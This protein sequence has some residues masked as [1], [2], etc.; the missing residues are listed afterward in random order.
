MNNTSFFNYIQP[1]IVK[2]NDNAA[3]PEQLRNHYLINMNVVGV[4]YFFEMFLLVKNGSNYE[5]MLT[6]KNEKIRLTDNIEQIDIPRI[7]LAITDKLTVDDTYFREWLSLS[8]MDNA[9]YYNGT[10]NF[11][12]GVD[13][14]L[15]KTA[16]DALL[17]Q[18]EKVCEPDTSKLLHDYLDGYYEV[19]QYWDALPDKLRFYSNFRY[20]Q[21]KNESIE[22]NQY[23]EDELDNLY[24]TFC[25]IILDQTTITD[26]QLSETT[27][28]IYR[29]VLEYYKGFMSDCASAGI[30]VIL[31][32][33]FSSLPEYAKTNSCGCGGKSTTST[34]LSQATSTESCAS[35]YSNAMTEYLK[36]MLGDTEFYKDWMWIDNND[37]YFSNDGLID[38]LITLLEEF[39]AIGYDLSFTESRP[40]YW[41]NCGNT[42]G[43]DADNCNHETIQNY[44]KVLNWVKNGQIDEN[45]N[46]IR[47]YGG[48]F[49]ELLP[50]LI[51]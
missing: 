26:S 15:N 30:S 7:Y 12:P 35:L 51:F 18:E 3:N 39:E 29:R 42:I 16:Y 11:V 25:K 24:S 32:T 44:I 17:I 10:D 6:N 34:S 37:H 8:L 21:N 19:T 27:N 1:T 46:K 49:A 5:Y 48:K 31:G 47:V 33:S 45:T 4:P 23:S 13:Y 50:K 28:N 40:I 9:V 43:S 2:L 36:K 22:T 14:W 20:F 41:C 38:N